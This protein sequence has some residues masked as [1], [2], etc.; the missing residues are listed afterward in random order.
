MIRCLYQVGIH[1]YSHDENDVAS[2]RT[3]RATT[4]TYVTKKVLWPSVKSSPVQPCQALPSIIATRPH[5]KTKINSFYIAKRCFRVGSG[6]FSTRFLWN[7]AS[8]C[9]NYRFIHVWMGNPSTDVTL[10]P[11]LT[12]DSLYWIA[13]AGDAMQQCIDRLF[14]PL[15]LSTHDVRNM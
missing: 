14:R 15:T 10:L 2:F 3:R 9:K 6:G 1:V 12:T 13:L 8:W 5:K 11:V 7:I 4:T